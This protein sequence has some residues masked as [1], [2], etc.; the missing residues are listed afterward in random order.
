MRELLESQIPERVFADSWNGVPPPYQQFLAAASDRLAMQ[1]SGPV[2]RFAASIRSSGENRVRIDGELTVPEGDKTYYVEMV[3][4]PSSG[5]YRGTARAWDTPPEPRPKSVDQFIAA[6]DAIVDEQELI[7]EGQAWEAAQGVDERA[8]D[9]TGAFPAVFRLFERF[10]DEDFGCP[11]PLVHL[12]VAR[13]GY[14]DLLLASITRA[15]SITVV[16]MVNRL[17]NSQLPR[18]ERSLWIQALRNAAH[19]PTAIEDVKSCAR[20]LL[21]YQMTR[22]NTEQEDGAGK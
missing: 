6:L 12:M 18:A 5:T 8:T 11:G 2:S 22:S 7:F 21:E 19:S 13:G 1:V 20:D 16:T 3:W 17:L 10:P 4:L 14:K 15:P 9:L